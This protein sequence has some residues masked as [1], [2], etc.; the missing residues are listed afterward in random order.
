MQVG[1]G[2]HFRDSYY[3]AWLRHALTE[4]ARANLLGTE[5]NQ[6]GGSVSLLNLALQH[7]RGSPSLRLDLPPEDEGLLTSLCQFDMLGC[8]A[9]LAAHGDFYP[10]F[11]QFYAERSDP[12]VLVVLDDET[13]R[14]K[15]FPGSDSDLAAALRSIGDV[16]HHQSFAFSGWQ[17]YEHPR[18]QAFL[19]QHPAPT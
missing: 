8:L 11:A 16:A 12:A 2:Y 14:S 10:S 9:E 7:V 15:I 6:R 17:G 18:I 13:A 5:P 1:S 3:P 4:A 19:D